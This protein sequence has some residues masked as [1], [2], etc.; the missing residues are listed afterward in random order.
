MVVWWRDQPACTAV[1][2]MLRSLRRFATFLLI[3]VL[4]GIACVM[5]RP[6][7]HAFFGALGA[8]AY[9]L[10]R[11]SRRVALANLR[12]VYGPRPTDR[13]LGDM[14]KRSFV[15]LGKFAFD[16]VKMDR[17]TPQRLERM[18][19]VIGRHH[20]DRALAEG[21]GAVAITGHIGNWEFMGGYLARIGYPLNV[22][23][24]RIRNSR[25]DDLLVGLRRRTGMKVLERS[26]GLLSAFRCLKKGEML[27]VLMDQDTSVESITVDFLGHPAK[28]PVGPAK[29]ASRTGAAVLPM[30][31]LMEPDGT[32]RIEIKEPIR[33][34]GDGALADDVEKCSRALEEF[35]ERE[36]AQWAWMH[37]RWKSV[38]SEMYA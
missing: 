28:T 20:L 24:T 27:G 37:K 16:A 1:T 14:A 32:Y 10:L 4:V 11:R 22:L 30:V 21:A 9:R 23:A 17:Y 6:L 34:N 29:L 15:N 35:I 13:Q 25:V 26:R 31:M 12:L 8:L 38:F 7:G 3:K 36:P 18:V 33:L 2:A 19:K 5:P